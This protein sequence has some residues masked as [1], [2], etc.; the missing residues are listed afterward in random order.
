MVALSPDTATAEDY[1]NSFIALGQQITRTRRQLLVTHYRFYRHQA[2][3]SQ[4]AE[5]MGWSSYSSANAHYGRLAQLVA[6]Q[7]GFQLNGARLNA[8]C[9]FV[10]PQEPGDHWLIIMRVQVVEALRQLGW[11]GAGRLRVES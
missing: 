1:Q 4:I 11:T 9:T 6:D 3:M 8:L 7:L 2:T 10:E 5:R